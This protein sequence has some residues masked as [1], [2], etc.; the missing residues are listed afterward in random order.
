M[1]WI[2]VSRGGQGEVFGG[3]TYRRTQASAMRSEGIIGFGG[4][5]VGGSSF[6][7]SVS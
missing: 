3:D 7:S 1:F 4:R 5:F 6:P 2:G